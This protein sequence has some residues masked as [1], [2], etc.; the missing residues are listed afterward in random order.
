MVGVAAGAGT[1][2]VRGLISIGARMRAIG[3]FQALSAAVLLSQNRLV[4]FG[5]GAVF[6]SLQFS[7]LSFALKLLVNPVSG[8]LALL[9]L[10]LSTRSWLTFERS[11]RR[12]RMQLRLMGLDMSETTNR[13]HELRTQ[14]G[15]MAA[16]EFFNNEKAI[17]Q[18][19]R[20]GSGL[21]ETLLG[22]AN[23]LRITGGDWEG[24]RD[25]MGE[26]FNGT[27]SQNDALKALK[28]IFPGLGPEITTV[29]E[30]LALIATEAQNSVDEMT[31]LEKIPP[32]IEKHTR[33]H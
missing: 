12:A 3:R 15:N 8:L 23:D 26:V 31:N 22:V 2:V 10:G 25:I 9:Q 29:A 1:S 6:A 5:R 16:R 30:A 17:Y 18:L 33:G 19:S 27:M 11:A 13:V 4:S 14:L 28:E 32:K 7:A 24:F 21:R 20:L